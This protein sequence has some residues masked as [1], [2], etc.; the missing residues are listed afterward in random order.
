MR[1]PTHA[2]QHRVTPVTCLVLLGLRRIAV[3]VN[4][5]DL[6]KLL[7]EVEQCWRVSSLGAA[8]AAKF[9]SSH[10]PSRWVS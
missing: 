6:R 1:F 4:D 2:M 10:S 7:V 9:G 3:A 8:C 5:N